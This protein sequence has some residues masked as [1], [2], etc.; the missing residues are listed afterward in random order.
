VRHEIK[1]LQQRLGITAVHVTHDREEA[2]V[3]ADRIALMDSG[4]IVQVATPEEV[5]N[6]PDSPFAATFMGAR[7]VVELSVRREGAQVVVETLAQAAPA[8]LPLAAL[9]RP[10]HC[11]EGRARAHFRGEAARLAPAGG[12][13]GF[14]GLR[15]AGVVR[16]VSYP[17]G[18]YR[19]AV[20]VGGHEYLVDDGQRFD[21][22]SAV[23]VRLP[24]AALHLFA[25][26]GGAA[27]AAR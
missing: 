3:M 26:G 23:E 12:P 4:R 8:R 13:D 22:G 25:D 15:L 9:P 5:F 11:P 1:A 14:A 7:H 2:M 17:G 27:A 6:R 16:Q 18:T 20:A 24:P 10:Q 19:H 21:V